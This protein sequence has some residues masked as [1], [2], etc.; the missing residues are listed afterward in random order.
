MALPK[1]IYG[2][3]SGVASPEELQRLR[4]IAASLAAPKETPNTIGNGIAA[5][6]DALGYRM[7][8]GKADR[9]SEAGNASAQDAVAKALG[10]AGAFPPAPGGGASSSAAGNGSLPA[11]D[12]S[13]TASGSVDPQ[14]IYAGL[15]ARGLNDAQAFAILGN[16]K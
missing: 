15:K 8:Q 14:A 1:F 2:G 5:I 4:E 6:G 11:V 9:M 13:K 16:W 7:T 10:G 3:T 12:V